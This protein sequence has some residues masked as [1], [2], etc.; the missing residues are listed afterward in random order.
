MRWWSEI[1]YHPYIT[2]NKG[3]ICMF[4]QSFSLDAS[5]SFSQPS[6]SKTFLDVVLPKTVKRAKKNLIIVTCSR[7]APINWEKI[8][9]KLFSNLGFNIITIF[10]GIPKLFL[11]SLA[12]YII[13]FFGGLVDCVSGFFP[14]KDV[15][16]DL[17][18]LMTASTLALNQFWKMKDFEVKI[19]IAWRKLKLSC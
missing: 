7:P 19:V 16:R 5:W 11:R 18:P 10:L 14:R 17:L 8:A 13:I 15:L 12:S 6:I 9:T 3:Q 2:C 1:N 4:L